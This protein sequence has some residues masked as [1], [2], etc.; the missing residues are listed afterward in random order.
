MNIEQLKE[1][2]KKVCAYHSDDGTSGYLLSDEQFELIFIIVE[3]AFQAG[4]L[5]GMDDAIKEIKKR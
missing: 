1:R 4:K 3:Q 2:I 5:A